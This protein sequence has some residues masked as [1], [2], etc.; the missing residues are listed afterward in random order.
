M[1]CFEYL[2]DDS[3]SRQISENLDDSESRATVLKPSLITVILLIFTATTAAERVRLT[4]DG[5]NK[6]DPRFIENGK[7]LIYC[8]DETQ[9]LVRMMRMDVEERKP[10]PVFTDAGDKHHLEPAVSP[11]GR[12]I[13]YTQCTGNLTAQ[14]VIRNLKDNKSAFVKHSGRGGT[15]SPVFSPDSK[16]VVY[17]FAETGPQQLWS[18]SIEAKEKKQ[19][20][21]SQG[22]S[23]WPTFTPDGKTLVF[24]NSRENNYEIYSMNLDGS[25]EKRL[26]TNKLMDI[27]P[28]VS[29]DGKRIAFVST[30]DGNYE[31]YIM[32]ID[33]T[34]V[35]RIT[36]SEERDDY[37]TWHPN[38]R[39]LVMVSERDGL[40]DLY[41]ADVPEP[42]V[43]AK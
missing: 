24:S 1:N 31:V 26:T 23:N 42:N 4:T 8:Y 40:F 38:G 27:R 14:L 33:G 29:P 37:P 5:T 22:V 7:T 39:Q 20:T 2:L 32:N 34:D 12:F 19:L 25:N 21:Q 11:D 3:P 10:T 28:A 35:R 30:R 43:A 41:L 36:H 13:A 17:A 6:R 9:A 18:V 15:R 16:L